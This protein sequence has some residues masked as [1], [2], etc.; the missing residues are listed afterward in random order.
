MK[1]LLLFFLLAAIALPA[2]RVQAENLTVYDDGKIYDRGWNR[3]GII[4]K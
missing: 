4:K 1:M 3:K 2:C